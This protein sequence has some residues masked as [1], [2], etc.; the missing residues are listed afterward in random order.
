LRRYPPPEDKEEIRDRLEV[1]II[2]EDAGEAF[3]K[4]QAF[5]QQIET[6]AKHGLDG[7]KTRYMTF[8]WSE[9]ARGTPRL[10]R[11]TAIEAVDSEVKFERAILDPI[12]VS[13]AGVFAGKANR[14]ILIEIS[15][16][17]F[18]RGKDVLSRKGRAKHDIEIALKELKDAQLLNSE[19]LLECRRAGAP[20]T[21]L[22]DASDL[23][24]ESVRRLKCP[25]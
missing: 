9:A 20:L 19:W 16:A 21:R 17:G 8:E 23:D 7:R 10:N 11:F 15:Q 14:Q 5:A 25:R 4:L 1:A 3:S 18:A 22:T 12:E 13:A 6:V 24:F 2:S